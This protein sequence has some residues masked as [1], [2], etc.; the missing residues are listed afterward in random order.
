MESHLILSGKN[1]NFARE[2]LANSN[3]ET[4]AY[5]SPINRHWKEDLGDRLGEGTILQQYYSCK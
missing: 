5:L 4:S 2:L 3:S 1:I